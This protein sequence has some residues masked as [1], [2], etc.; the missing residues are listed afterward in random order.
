MEGVWQLDFVGEACLARFNDGMYMI[1]HNV[2]S[3]IIPDCLKYPGN[4]NL[5]YYFKKEAHS[6]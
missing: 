1:W 3:G 6:C 2:G 4:K 5:L